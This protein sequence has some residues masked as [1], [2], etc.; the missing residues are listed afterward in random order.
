MAYLTESELA[1]ARAD[2]AAKLTQLDKRISR[3][4]KRQLAK[5]EK[6]PVTTAN[7]NTLAL[8]NAIRCH[9]QLAVKPSVVGS[10][11]DW[12]RLGRVVIKGGKAIYILPPKGS[13][14]AVFD[15]SQ[16]EVLGRQIKRL[17]KVTAT[18]K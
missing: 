3:L 18:L 17:H 16:T 8:K 12:M 13:A 15:I 9:L 1:K 7:G 5:Y 2:K 11:Q 10:Y 6:L 4:T 14:K